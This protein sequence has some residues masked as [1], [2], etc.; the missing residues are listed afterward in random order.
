MRPVREGQAETQ[1]TFVAMEARDAEIDGAFCHSPI[2]VA[3]S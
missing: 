1:A 3:Q 2:V